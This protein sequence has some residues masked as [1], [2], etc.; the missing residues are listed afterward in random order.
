MNLF[1]TWAARGFLAA[2]VVLSAGLAAAD[3]TATTQAV[4]QTKEC[5]WYQFGR[6]NEV[7]PQ[8][9]G[10]PAEAP[11]TGTIVTVDV[12]TNTAYL[13]DNGEL[14]QKSKVATGS[15]KLLK[16]GK[17]FWLFRTPRGRH[18]VL[19][20][21]TDPVWTKPDWAL[22]EEGKAVP[23]PNSPS[24]QV[25]GKMGKYALDLGDGILIHGTD[26]PNSFGRKASHGCIRMPEEMLEQ[27]YSMATVGTE[28]Y[29]F[30]SNPAP[31]TAGGGMNDLDLAGRR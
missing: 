31:Q 23:P 17:R 15:D 13:F 7:R 24:R 20:K 2:S 3:D 4:D 10:L 21:I 14:L 18:K 11:S 30:E 8:I 27:V 28:V 19:R 25:K 1:S 5:H 6:C 9:E 29:I 12:S 26:D 16:K 22:V